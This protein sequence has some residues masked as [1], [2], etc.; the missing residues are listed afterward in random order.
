MTNDYPKNRL[1]INTY[2]NKKGVKKISINLDE[3]LAKKLS[4]RDQQVIDAIAFELNQ[5]LEN[6]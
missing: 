6:L 3:E 2:V 5:D 4:N 1:Y